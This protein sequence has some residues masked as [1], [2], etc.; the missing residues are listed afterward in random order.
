MA[1][2]D[3]KVI[4]LTEDI[5]L[6]EIDLE[7]VNSQLNDY[8]TRIQN[9]Y[10]EKIPLTLKV[11]NLAQLESSKTHIE[12]KVSS[13]RNDLF[14]AKSMLG[15][16]S[17]RLERAREK[18][19]NDYATVEDDYSYFSI[20]SKQHDALKN[21]LKLMQQD[22]IGKENRL[23]DL[24]KHVYDPECDF[25]VANGQSTIIATD[26][27]LMEIAVLQTEIENLIQDERDLGERVGLLS[28]VVEKHKKYL[29]G[30]TFI[31]NTEKEETELTV[32]QSR[33]EFEI[34]QLEQQLANVERD[35]IDYQ[36][37][38]ESIAKNAGIDEKIRM[39]EIEKQQH[40]NQFTVT[41][42]A[43]KGKHGECVMWEQ[44]KR[45][46]LT[47]IKEAEELETKYEVYEAYLAAVC[48]DGLPYK[49]IAEVLP[50]LQNAVNNILN[51]MTEFSLL[52]DMDGKN[53]NMRLAYDDVRVW[54][55]ELASGMEKFISGLAIRVAL[56]SLSSLPK[57]N[58][59]IIDEGLGALDGDNL[60]SIFGL[61]DVLR[62]QFDFLFLISHVDSVRDVADRL[63]EIK[64]DNGFSQIVV[65]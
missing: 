54:P 45:D 59:L 10:G 50:D 29:I 30:Q 42:Q 32:K 44:K 35:I 47:R 62:T 13:R 22:L 20:V 37:S 38:V 48:R 8:T 21:K 4:A 65:K 58:F 60:S 53:V 14:N 36:N 49:M 33:L 7:D 41:Q 55:L 63:I 2:A 46:M 64:R 9:L 43:I 23:T 57:S 61:F 27:V 24:Q 6:L 40:K 56:T 39:L 19:I 25:C 18:L 28:H 11:T 51:Q 3:S 12:G 5:R 31:R 26:K 34:A 16:V 15:T 17:D 52:F 1:D